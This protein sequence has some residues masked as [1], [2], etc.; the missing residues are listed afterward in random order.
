MITQVRIMNVIE[1]GKM[2]L[3]FRKKLG[4]TQMELAQKLNVTDKAVSK[5]ENGVSQS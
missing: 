4:L 1:F 3:K 5:W 2:I